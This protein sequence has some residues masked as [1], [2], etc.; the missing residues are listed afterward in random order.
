ME[1]VE[2]GLTPISKKKKP[3]LSLTDKDVNLGR[4][5]VGDK[6]VFLISAT[7][8]LVS[9]NMDSSKEINS[10]LIPRKFDYE[11]EIEEIEVESGKKKI[12]NREVM[13]GRLIK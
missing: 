13:D 11:F 12:G 8:R 6:Y 1:S 9:Q 3:R 7:V 10:E 5:T 4:I 2:N